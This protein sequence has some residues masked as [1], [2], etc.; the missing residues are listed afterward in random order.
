M[1]CA[2][3]CSHAGIISSHACAVC[4]PPSSCDAVQAMIDVCADAGW[5]DSVLAVMSLTQ[6]V[7]QAAWPDSQAV[8]GTL[9]PALAHPAALQSLRRAGCDLLPVLVDALA[10]DR[11]ATRRALETAVH[12]AH[13][14]ADA[15]RDRRVPPAK[16]EADKV[17]TI[18]DRFPI[19]DVGVEWET[20]GTEVA[21]DRAGNAV[22]CA[23][24]S[25][26][27]AV[28]VTLSR[29]HHGSS[30][31]AQHRTAPRAHA[32]HFP[33]VRTVS[34]PCALVCC[35][36]GGVVGTGTWH[37]DDGTQTS[38][39]AYLAMHQYHLVPSADPVHTPMKLSP[40][41]SR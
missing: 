28:I 38:R 21:Q 2:G 6:G 10:N 39:D 25:S 41:S 40:D 26:N 34:C 23:L 27:R 12:S 33:K 35:P 13:A 20:I 30:T 24:D 32:P 31:G 29:Q 37:G 15:E 16:V 7:M 1:T 18:L 22:P 3:W 14:A 36:G 19:I 17:A 4:L 11:D 8:L 9:S 5:L